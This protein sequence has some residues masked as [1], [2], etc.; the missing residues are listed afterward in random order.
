MTGVWLV[1]QRQKAAH[2]SSAGQRKT[3][4]LCHKMAKEI[5]LFSLLFPPISPSLQKGCCTISSSSREIFV[6]LV[7]QKK[8][9]VT[10]VGQREREGWRERER[11]RGGGGERE[12]ERER[13]RE[14]IVT[15]SVQG[16]PV[17]SVIKQTAT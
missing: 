8:I 16:T 7:D 3:C 4:S 10:P 17:E 15:T 2:V 13:E 11:E 6:S 12:R 5:E 1:D 9:N 14:S